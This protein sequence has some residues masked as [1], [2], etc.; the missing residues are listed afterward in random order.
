MYNLCTIWFSRHELFV[1]TLCS[2][3]SIVPGLHLNQVIR[4]YIFTSNFVNSIL[5]LKTKTISRIY[6]P[7]CY[8]CASDGY[9]N[10]LKHSFDGTSNKNLN[11]F[12]MQA[13]LG[14]S[15]CLPVS[16]GLTLGLS[17]SYKESLFNTNK[18]V[19]SEISRWICS[20]FSARILLEM[21]VHVFMTD[22]E[23]NAFLLFFHPECNWQFCSKYIRTVLR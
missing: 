20:I 18:K 9:Q 21:C 13:F 15:K 4:E 1:W 11:W 2:F 16:C 19:S 5:A 10:I 12:Q 8:F 3:S 14:R 23:T 6:I 17:I 22:T 7:N